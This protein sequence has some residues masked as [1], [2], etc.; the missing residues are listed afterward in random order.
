MLSLIFSLFFMFQSDNPKECKDT[1]EKLCGIERIQVRK[2]EGRERSRRERGRERERKRGRESEREREKERE[3][4]D[5]EEREEREM[6]REQR[7]QK[8]SENDARPCSES[9]V[10]SSNWSQRSGHDPCCSCH[11]KLCHTA[12]NGW[13]H[14][15]FSLSLSVICLLFSLSVSVQSLFS[16][17][18]FLSP[19][20]LS[21]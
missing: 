18:L 15:L 9:F 6:R 10:R 8:K 20:L 19:S 13:V 4:K 12:K 1:R 5:R 2:K 3:E 21:L 16:L 11:S 17:F 7:E 14:S